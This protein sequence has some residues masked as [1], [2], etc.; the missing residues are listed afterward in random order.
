MTGIRWRMVAGH[1]RVTI[2]IE[3]KIHMCRTGL[4]GGRE[5]T[6]ITMSYLRQWRMPHLKAESSIRKR[7]YGIP[8][9]ERQID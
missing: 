4:G 7:A 2:Y 8:Y 5:M 6:A 3:G 9:T 1:W